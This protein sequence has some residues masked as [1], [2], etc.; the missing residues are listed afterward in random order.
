MA[1]KNARD[2]N[3]IEL[4]PDLLEGLPSVEDIKKELLF[5]PLSSPVWSHQ[6][7]RLIELYL[8][9]FVMVTK[10]GTY[11]DGFAGPQVT[12]QPES[13]SAKR[14]LEREPRF[15]RNFFLCELDRSKVPKLEELWT[16]QPPRR[17]N[18]S[19]RSCTVLHGDFNILVD[20]ILASGTI[21][22]KEATF[23]LLDQRTFE[24]H[25]ETVCKL[26]GHKKEGNKIE[27]FYFLAVKWIHRSFGGIGTAGGQAKV[28]AWWGGPGWECL[29]GTSQNQLRDVM[30]ERFT[31]ELGYRYAY[32]FPIWSKEEG[33]GGSIMYYMIHA[34]DHDDAPR[35]MFRA[36]KNAIQPLTPQEQFKLGL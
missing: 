4:F 7:A 13:W 14:V 33:D 29:S 16:I 18:E 1:R 11:I 10:H 5:Q 6:K 26:A 9:Y 36:Y 22:E 17:K 3:T 19:K 12:D 15:L 31:N 2:P 28:N 24:C 21:T 30:C 23:A 25:W 27:L 32:P 34:T 20:E 8:H 35:L